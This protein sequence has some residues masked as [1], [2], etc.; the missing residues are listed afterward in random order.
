M[1]PFTS[2]KELF[3]GGALTV[4]VVAGSVV[5]LWPREPTHDGKRLS[6]WLDQLAATLNVNE[7]FVASL[8]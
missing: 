4:V 3:L 8:S 7:V 1:R 6:Y 5:A 2:R